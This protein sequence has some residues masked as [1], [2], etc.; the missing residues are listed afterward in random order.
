MAM[1]KRRVV[2]AGVVAGSVGAGALLGATLFTPGVGFAATDTELGG[3]IE[4]VCER[5]LGAGPIDVAAETI[6]IEPSELLTELRDGATIAEVAQEHG[7]E[8]QAVIDA[9]VAEQRDRLDQAVEDG[10]LTQDEAD[11][12]AADLEER[13][14]DLVNG[15]LD[16]P[17]WGHGPLVGHPGLWGFADGPLT[18]A[19]NAIGIEAA[20]L[21]NELRD[22]ATIAEVA[23]E[24][25]VEASEVVD[26]IVAALQERLDAAVENGWITQEQADERAAELEEQATAIVNGDAGFFPFPGP[27]GHGPGMPWPGEDD[28]DAEAGTTETSLF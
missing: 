2:M 21:L 24:H 8:P 22:G 16:L 4:Q 13:A 6:G 18:A 5:V 23:D 1:D 27:R 20:G 26:A 15:D 3:R 17:M 11:A 10:L 28:A 9:I 19:A 7:V 25:G 12:G 14:T